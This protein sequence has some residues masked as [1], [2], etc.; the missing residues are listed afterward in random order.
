MF[1]TFNG[2]IEHLLTKNII[3]FKLVMK[4]NHITENSNFFVIFICITK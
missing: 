1:A 4:K 2:N 3:Q